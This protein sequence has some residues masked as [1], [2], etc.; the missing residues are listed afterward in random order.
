[1]VL[2]CE[3]SPILNLKLDP[4][5]DNTSL[6]AA[7]TNTPVNKW[8]VSH[9]DNITNGKM[10]EGEEIEEVEEDICITDIDD[11]QPLFTQPLA[12]IPGQISIHVYTIMVSIEAMDHGCGL[13]TGGRSIRDFRILSNR[14]Q[15]LTK[16]SVGDVAVWDVLHVREFL[17]CKVENKIMCVCVFRR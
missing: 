3:D 2:F 15:V 9:P 17:R 7:T 1:M 11:P 10:E 5:D 8:P 13:N 12:T 6:W 16:D 4:S 14:Q